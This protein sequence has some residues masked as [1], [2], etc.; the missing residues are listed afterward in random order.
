M[1]TTEPMTVEEFAEVLLGQPLWEHQRDFARS[2]ARYR[3][4][5]AGRQVGKSRTLAVTA[6]YEAFT[7]RNV[8]V[9]LVSAGE[10]ASRRLLEECASLA[11]ASTI[12]RGSVLDDS[13]STMTISNGSRIISVPASQRQIR[14]WPVDVLIID[15]AGFVDP[16]IWRA[17]EPAIIARPG[18]KVILSSSPWGSAQ[19]FFRSLWNRGMLTP[20]EQVRSWHWPSSTSPMVDQQLLD[21][22]QA[23]E[24]AEYFRREFLAEWTDAAGAYFTQAELDDAVAGYTFGDGHLGNARDGMVVGGIDYGFANDANVVTLLGVLD[25]NHRNKRTELTYYVPHIESHY[26]MPYAD[27]INRLVEITDFY[28][29]VKYMSELNG[30]GAY[31]TEELRGRLFRKERPGRPRT[32]VVG[33]TTDIRRKMSGFGALKVLLQQGRIVLPRHPELL[34]QLASLEFEQTTT[35]QMKISVPEAR[36]HDDLAMSLM[37]A[38]STITGPGLFDWYSSWEPDYL[39]GTDEP[40]LQTAGGTWIPEHPRTWDLQYAFS[41]ARGKSAGDGW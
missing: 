36:G 24:T 6:L 14:G 3:V 38:V 28:H 27:F 7:R 18:S 11:T 39:V 8:T 32:Q 19:H 25:D 5:C 12:L 26:R 21:E 40:W 20:D 4:M 22:I 1:T 41:R 16:E 37:Q 34:K 35:G 33:V 23:R 17:A 9:L 31:P 29:V 13:K 15:E 2:T 10:T 30:P